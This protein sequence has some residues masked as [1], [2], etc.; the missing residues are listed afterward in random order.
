MQTS[1]TVK[2]IAQLTGHNGAIFTLATE[3]DN[4]HIIS[5]AG[6]GWVVRWNLDA[7][8]TGRLL[9]KVDTNIFSLCYL[10]ERHQLVVGNMNGGVHWVDIQQPERT[11]NIAH[12]KKG[13]YDI[14]QM[15]DF[16]FTAGGEGLLTKWSI[17][18]ART[19]E[20]LQLTNQN[21]RSLDYSSN[22]K[23]LAI[24]SSDNHIYLLHAETLEIKANIPAHENSV[25]TVRYSPDG[26]YL[27]SGGRDAH[28]KIWDLDTL[29]PVSSQPAHWFT[30]NHIVFH[31]NGQL[32]ATASRD[33][34]IKIWDAETFQ[35]LKVIDTFKYRCHINSV[36]RLLW[37]THNNYLV[38]ASD[39]RTM[40]IWEI[41]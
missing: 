5:G 16:I 37:T 14:R 40:I 32:F 1:L 25:F 29:Q 41:N 26:R 8:E 7:P 9:A 21:L 11:K 10:P 6:D 13:V 24:G 19:L 28:L 38:S 30:I 3:R 4:Q 12:H 2:K 15:G 33:K 35:L 22:R 27:L 34:T 31:P 17:E 23:E 39:D 36:N 18:E 20:S